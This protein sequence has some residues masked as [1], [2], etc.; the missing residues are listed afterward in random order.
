MRDINRKLNFF[1]SFFSF[2]II[3]FD[4]HKVII[5]YQ[6]YFI[7]DVSEDYLITRKLLL[8]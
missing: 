8:L 3:N 7:K 5:L 1:F 4:F 6:N 2:S